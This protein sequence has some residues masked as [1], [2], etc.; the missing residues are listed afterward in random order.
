M[1]DSLELV[2]AVNAIN[3]CALLFAARTTREIVRLV[4]MHAGSPSSRKLTR[5]DIDGLAGFL[6]TLADNLPTM[7]PVDTDSA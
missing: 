4:I 6:H 5:R 3:P 7:L 2:N 1:E